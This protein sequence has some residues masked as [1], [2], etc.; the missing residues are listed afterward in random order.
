[1]AQVHELL[2]EIINYL[3]FRKWVDAEYKKF[4]NQVGRKEDVSFRREADL[5]DVDP[6][7]RV[8]AK[9]Y[10]VS[11]EDLKSR[12]YGSLARPVAARML[13]KHAGMN[14]RE[15]GQVLGYGTG[16]SVSMQLKRVRTEIKNNKKAFRQVARI[17][18]RIATL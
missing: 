17:D 8:V 12:L 11:V 14:Q 10:R 2:D 7:L 6:I 18:K 5:T 9:A 3:G 15:A 13:C 16:A 1:M 4:R